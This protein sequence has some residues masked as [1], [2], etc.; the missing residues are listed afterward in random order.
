MHYAGAAFD[1]DPL[2]TLADKY[3][4]PVI[5][6]AA[7]A[8]GARA[9]ARL[10][11]VLLLARTHSPLRRGDALHDAPWWFY[12]P[13]LVAFSLPWVALLPS[14]LKQAWDTRRQ[15]NIAFLLLWRL[16]PLIFSA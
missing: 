2:Y 10:L 4:I 9:G 14:A 11:A 1:L 3:G 16:M 5:E 7:H 15:A 13:L 8:A 12:L 6:D